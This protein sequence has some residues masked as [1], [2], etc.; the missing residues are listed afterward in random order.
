M[1]KIRILNINIDN[2]SQNKL[3]DKL[4]SGIL[5]TPNVDHLVKLQTD[6]N[7]YNIYNKSDWVICDSKIL[8]FASK[9]LKV[10]LPEAIPG[11]SFFT[12]FCQ[13]HKNDIKCKIFILGAAKGVASKAMERINNTIGRKL[14][15]GEFSPSFGFE[16]NDIECQNI[17]EAIQKSEANV[18][19]VGLGAPKQEKWIFKYKDKLPNIDIFMALGATIDFESGYRKRA[20]QLIQKIGMEWFYRFIKEPKRLYRRYFIDDLKFFWY[21]GRQLLGIYKNPFDDN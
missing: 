4:K 17:V 9:L 12:S 2:I 5:V 18:V 16:K 11:S 21:F 20:P 3:L 19:L 7:F 8:Y 14:V 1:N 13:Y 10:S 6:R 15:V